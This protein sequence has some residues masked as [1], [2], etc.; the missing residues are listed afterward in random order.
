MKVLHIIQRYP[1]AIGG[2]EVW[3]KNL[4]RFLARK[5][6]IVTV[7]TINLY[8]IEE[9]SINLALDERYVSMGEYDNDGGVFVRRYPVWPFWK[10]SLSLRIFNFLLYKLR[11]IKTEI[12]HIFRHSPN[13]MVMYRNLFKEIK[14][15]DVI[16]LHTLPYFHNI[17]GYYIAKICRKKIVITPHFHPGHKEYEKRIL[18]KIMN[19]CD[20]IVVISS[21]EKD[22]LEKRGLK[23]DKIFVAGCAL[24]NQKPIEN[25]ILMSER[26]KLFKKHL[27]PMDDSKKIL[28]IG[29]KELYKGIGDLIQVVE[30]LIEKDGMKILL[31]LVGPDTVDFRIK[32]GDYIE[33]NKSKTK[34]VDFGEVSDLEKEVL[35]EA[36]DMLVL[37]SRYESFGIVF[38]EAW[39]Y[40]KP[41]IGSDFGAVPEVIKNAGLCVECG[42]I[43]DLK[44]KIKLLLSDNKLARNLGEVGKKKLEKEYSL[45]NIGNKVLNVYYNLDSYKKRVLIVSNLFPP[46]CDGGAEIVAYEQARHLKNMGFDITIFTGKQDDKKIQYEVGVEKKPFKITRVNFHAVDF[47][48]DI[49]CAKNDFLQEKFKKILYE[50]APDIVHFHNL[51]GFPLGMIDDCRNMNIPVV[52]TL[53]DYW[54]L[55]Y[56]KTLR[57]NNGVLCYS[58]NRECLDCAETIFSNKSASISIAERNSLLAVYLNSINLLISPSEYLAKKFIDNGV[59]NYRLKVINNGIDTKRFH[60]LKKI[61]SKKIRFGFIGT[62]RDHKGVENLLKSL[63]LLKD[64]GEENFSLAIAGKGDALFVNYLKRLINDLKIS[65]FVYFFGELDNRAIKKVYKDIDLLVVSSVWPENSP[66]TIMEAFAAGTPVLASD[67]GGIPELIEHGVHGYLHKYDDPVSLADNMKEIISRPDKLK[68]MKE[69]CLKKACDLTIKK[70]VGLIV[71][72]YKRLTW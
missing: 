64:G 60:N 30:E 25:Q 69:A 47:K 9:C 67:I 53:H 8:K 16:H 49:V 29:R 62:L 12:G 18:F 5:G 31:F 68:I 65:H 50:I 23:P 48:Q 52:M 34:I 57:K 1:P 55:C 27:I 40:G 66:V 54:W 14:T 7:S 6:V 37:P 11:L 26:E 17:I 41:V 22:Y 63:A 10:M 46:H 71:K 70:Q 21:Y 42:D 44:N 38:L 15:A 39:K 59:S 13:S 32:Y 35:L 28:F 3:C 61:R 51:N 56:R 24:L 45:E 19:N 33:N 36:C 72:E 58:N 43:S 20:A 4:C 2:S